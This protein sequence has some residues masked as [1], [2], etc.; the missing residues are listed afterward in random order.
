MPQ[1]DQPQQKAGFCR[2]RMERSNSSK[3]C[4]K[5]ENHGKKMETILRF[6]CGNSIWS[7]F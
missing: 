6:F 5:M 7:A 4:E 3:H 1:D 2:E